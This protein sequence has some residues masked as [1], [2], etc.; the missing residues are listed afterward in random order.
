MRVRW[1]RSAR[2]VGALLVVA[3]TAG[4]A[5]VDAPQVATAGGAC[6]DTATYRLKVGSEANWYHLDTY[7]TPNGQVE[8]KKRFVRE[9]V[10][11]GTTTL[12][13]DMCKVPSTGEWKVQRMLVRAPHDDLEVTKRGSQITTIKPADSDYGF[14][15][16]IRTRSDSSVTFDGTRCT[17]EPMGAG[18]GTYSVLKGVL[19]LPWKVTTPVGVGMFVVGQALPDAPEGKYWCARM[20]KPL[21][22]KVRFRA[23]DG[24]PIAQ[25]GK[26]VPVAY[27]KTKDD[28]FICN[29]DYYSYCARSD[30]QTV[31]LKRL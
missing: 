9:N 6:S 10:R 22:L 18:W 17:Q 16:F 24:K 29:R 1:T 3:V 26:R 15:A 8:S 28:P 19:N 7:R 14:G 23:S 31:A 12:V 2:C 20:G 21:T 4:L 13:Y 25:W 5:L 27:I 30:W 11:T